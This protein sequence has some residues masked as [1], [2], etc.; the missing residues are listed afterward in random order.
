MLKN[1]KSSHTLEDCG[2]QN[3]RRLWCTKVVNRPETVMKKIW[4]MTQ[5]LYAAAV[6]V[7][8]KKCRPTGSKRHFCQNFKK[9]FFPAR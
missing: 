4:P 2:A 9:T 5:Q 8:T 6:D 7:T 1:A 3:F